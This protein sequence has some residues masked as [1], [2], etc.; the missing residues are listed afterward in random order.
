MHALRRAFLAIAAVA[1]SAA[2]AAAQ[3]AAPPDT[4]L[5]MVWVWI[6]VVGIIIMI[7]GTSIVGS[8]K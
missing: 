1:G 2:P 7:V 3:T 6:L 8:Q 4:G 5:F